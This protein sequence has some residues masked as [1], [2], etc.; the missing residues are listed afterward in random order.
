MDRFWVLLQGILVAAIS[1]LAILI[2]GQKSGFPVAVVE[3]FGLVVWL[4]ASGWYLLRVS[5]QN[6]RVWR[7]EAREG[8][9][10]SVL[11]FGLPLALGLVAWKSPHLKGWVFDSAAA[12]VTATCVALI[13]TAALA[14]SLLD[15]YVVLPLLLGL[16]GDPIWRDRGAI[17]DAG[18]RRLAQF[19]IAHRAISELLIFPAIALILAVILVAAGNAL[20]ADKTL[21]TA[22][23]SLGGASIAFG[24][25]SFAGPRWRNSL[26]FVL[27]GPVA[28][29]AWVEG[30][31]E[32]FDP[33]V[34]LVI[35]VSVYP[36]VKIID[37]AADR[38]FTP[39]YL[40]PRLN[41]QE[42]RPAEQDETWSRRQV[43]RHVLKLE[44][45]DEWRG[46]E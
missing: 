26:R 1:V 25:F 41:P 29:G 38:H 46:P 44:N 23:E 2:C 7:T 45:P 39:L 19:W 18:R 14:S 16:R 36:G 40:A 33:V 10:I 22:I 31:D 5:V 42:A 17:D 28:L 6:R 24:V 21:P 4:S 15:R 20:S 34:G 11:G 13:P 27:A 35:D 9:I 32:F 43:V 8:A 37:A 12:A 3:A 30:V